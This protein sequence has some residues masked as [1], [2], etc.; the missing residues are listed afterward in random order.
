MRGE[1]PNTI[2]CENTP[3]IGLRV[4]TTKKKRRNSYANIRA[5]FFW[6]RV[7]RVANAIASAAGLPAATDVSAIYNFA[8][9]GPADAPTEID[10]SLKGH[11]ITVNLVYDKENGKQEI[12]KKRVHLSLAVYKLITIAKRAFKMNDTS[13]N[14]V[15]ISA[16]VS[17]LFPPPLL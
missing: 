5:I 17:S 13:V 12:V 1:A 4:W 8:E 9:Y 14:L 6:F 2:I 16:K 10:P 3:G 7:R 11:L 15:R